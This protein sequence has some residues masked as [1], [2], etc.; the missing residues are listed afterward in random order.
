MNNLRVAHIS[1][2]FYNGGGLVKYVQ[3][4]V[5][6]QN[7]DRKFEYVCVFV[8]GYYSIFNKSVF[9]TEEKL[10][11]IDIFNINNFNPDTLL[12]GTK[13]PLKSI[14]NIQLENV[15][16]D[17]LVNLKIDIVHFHTFFGLSSNLIKKINQK[18]IKVIYTAHDHQPLCTKTTLI[19]KNNNLCTSNKITDCAM[20]NLNALT[21][22]NIL[23]RYCKISNKLKEFDKIKSKI[24]SV[25][26]KH[27]N[28]NNNDKATISLDNKDYI[29]RRN[30]FIENL[31][32]CCDL[33]IFSSEITYEIYKSFG[34][35]SNKFKVIPISNSNIKNNI[36][37]YE[38]KLKSKTYRF[39]YLGGDRIEK[40][41]H[42]MIKSFEKL[43]KEGINNW[44]LYIYGKGAENIKFNRQISDNVIIKGYTEKNLYDDF[45][46]LLVPSICPETFNFAVLEGL[47]NNKLIIASD[48]V[49]SADL[50]K[51]NGLITYKHKDE[52]DLIRKLKGISYE[53]IYRVDISCN[54]YSKNLKF[55]N[56][57]NIIYDAYI[58]IL[59]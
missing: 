44:E 55:S 12:E 3:D 38:I 23:L 59:S 22:K 8:P 32:N 40:G 54:D 29:K 18:N 52:D 6:E 51:Q 33:V 7:K 58:D 30:S 15:I 24:K 56:H 34:F 19:N 47:N 2:P 14:Q 10:N 45:D 25:V 57:I 35:N 31:N 5:K 17:K 49:G 16:V 41:Y 46:I 28:K 20:C 36:D 50:Y 42:H 27:K 21:E 9:I 26:I 11:D 1:L 37:S 4:L 53:E 13:Y 43:S 39:G 48:I